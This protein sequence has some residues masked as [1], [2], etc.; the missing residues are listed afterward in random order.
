MAYYIRKVTPTKWNGEKPDDGNYLKLG[1]DGV[2]NCCRTT[3]N[4]L[5]IWKT[6]SND[7]QSDENKTLLAAIATGS[8]RPATM[9]FIFISDTELQENELSLKET[10]GKTPI[11]SMRNLHR[12]IDHLDIDKLGKLGMLI[13][14]KVNSDDDIHRVSQSTIK[15]YVRSN[16]P[17]GSVDGEILKSIDGWSRLYN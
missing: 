3:D 10:P 16:F 12:D 2:T 11:E 9:D 13:H 14:E 6:D 17:D 4:E 8:D 7:P 15:Q 5:S 1:T